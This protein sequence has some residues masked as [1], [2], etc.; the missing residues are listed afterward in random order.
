MEDIMVH[1]IGKDAPTVD[2]DAFV[3]WNAEV[4]GAA[5][6]GKDVS[7]WFSTTVR[8]DMAPVSIGAGSNL[9]DGTVVHVD[10]DTPTIVGENV[11]VGHRVILH[12]CKVG[13]GSLIGMGAIMLNG[14][15]VGPGSIV[16]A[17]ALV[18]QGK[19]FPARSML[20][21]SPARLVRE[22]TDEEAAR[23]LENARRYVEMGRAAKASACGG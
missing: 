3:A 8:A 23:S 19:K 7:V 1:R 18:T 9:Q 15:E 4:A 17:G 5:S 22:V 6:I 12:G 20:I 11:T 13:D 2:P 14:S 21:G 16:G 10:R